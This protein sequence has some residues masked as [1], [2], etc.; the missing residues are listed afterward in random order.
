MK[1]RIKYIRINI[2][3]VKKKLKRK[4]VYMVGENQIII[5]TIWLVFYDNL[6]WII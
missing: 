5:E 3:K 4:Y 2:L 1:Y 6:I